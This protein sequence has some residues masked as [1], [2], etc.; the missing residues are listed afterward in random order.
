MQ[1]N[2][3]YM[4]VFACRIY[5]GIGEKVSQQS[6]G[7]VKE[8]AFNP[9]CGVCSSQAR[10]K[11]KCRTHRGIER[12]Q[13]TSKKKQQVLYICT[14]KDCGRRNPVWFYRGKIEKTKVESTQGRHV[15]GRAPFSETFL[16]YISCAFCLSLMYW[17]PAWDVSFI[18]SFF[19]SAS[20]C[21]SFTSLVPYISYSPNGAINRL[22]THWLS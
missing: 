13:E 14:E 20:C 2:G 22:S 6:S 12:K 3:L 17:A 8:K 7:D 5:C 10:R 16:I 18:F 21:N 15:R 11:M 1:L 19:S 9:C 4:F